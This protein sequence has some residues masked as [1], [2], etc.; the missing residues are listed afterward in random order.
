VS[1]KPLQDLRTLSVIV[2]GDD[3]HL[4]FVF[5]KCSHRLRAYLSELLP[6]TPAAGIQQ[7]RQFIGAYVISIQDHPVFT[8][9]QANLAISTAFDAAAPGDTIEFVFAVDSRADAVD[10]RRPPLHL[11]LSQLKRIHALRTVSGEGDSASASATIPSPPLRIRSPTPI[12]SAWH[13][14]VPINETVHSIT[15]VAKP[16]PMNRL[17]VY[18]PAH[19]IHPSQAKLKQLALHLRL[20]SGVPRNGSSSTLTRSRASLASLA[21]PSPAPPSCAPTGTTTSNR[22]GLVK[23]VCAA[24]DPSVLRRSYA[25]PKRTPPMHASALCFVRRHG[26]RRD[27][28]RLH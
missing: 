18:L 13:W 8:V 10:L 1:E 26:F 24:M 6:R 5:S 12:Y 17:L 22:V 20:I 7:R 11:Q 2:T 14:Y 27:G 23:L 16:H 21:L 4:G 28:R 15:S 9:E 3:A 25:S 19:C